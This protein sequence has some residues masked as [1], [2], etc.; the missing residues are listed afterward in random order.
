MYKENTPLSKELA[1]ALLA[2]IK[3]LAAALADN[4]GRLPVIMEVCGTHTVALARTGLRSLLADYLDLRSGPGCPVCVTAPEE[5]DY[6]LALARQPKVIIAT[7]G[8]MMRV[9]G[10]NGSLE[11]ARIDGACI[12]IC[13]S[14]REA[15]T[16]AREHPEA[17]VVFLGIGFETTAPTVALAVKEAAALRLKNFTLYSAH[18]VVPPALDALIAEPN[19]KLDGLLLPGHVSAIL[20]RRAFNF[21]AKKYKMP[22]VVA[23]FEVL[24]ILGALLEI[25]LML[26]RGTWD[27]INAYPRVV[28]EE[29]NVKA[30][31]I[32]REVFVL[33]PANWRGLGLIPLSGLQISPLYR[34]FDAAR[35]WPMK[36]TPV[37]PPKGCVCGDI[38][39]GRHLPPE[40]P[41]F[42]HRCTPVHPVGPCMVSS[43]GSCAAYFRY[44]ACPTL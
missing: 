33:A 26:Q 11:K 20:G 30:Q 43:E 2:K 40:C 7:F 29:G 25:L 34:N 9:P 18:K 6:M 39:K 4:L 28:T 1:V 38:L 44:G 15:L 41:L 3:N 17:E 12:H 37:P 24:D 13:Y 31:I 22:A 32:M 23:G 10:S 35:R 36:F 8:D 14:P 27:V 16:L 5:I 19:L 21:L 42:G